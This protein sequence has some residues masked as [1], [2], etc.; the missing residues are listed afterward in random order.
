[1]PFD[2]EHT[3]ADQTD[4][5]ALFGA[6]LKQR[7]ADRNMHAAQAA[8]ETQRWTS[9]WQKPRNM[10]RVCS[11]T[12]MTVTLAAGSTVLRARFACAAMFK[13]S[14][15]DRDV[16]DLLPDASSLATSA[17][18]GGVMRGESIPLCSTG[19]SSC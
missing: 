15:A 5:Q 2:G 14:A 18:R 1:M 8:S 7:Q 11:R 13:A 3:T 6:S 16:L 19:S 10:Q 12:S 9:R 4:T 17:G